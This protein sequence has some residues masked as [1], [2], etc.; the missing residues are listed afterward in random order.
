[1]GK[2]SPEAVGTQKEE[3]PQTPGEGRDQEKASLKPRWKEE[4]LE[5]W[6]PGKAT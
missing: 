5:T 1:M 3:A 2:I 4:S 6:D